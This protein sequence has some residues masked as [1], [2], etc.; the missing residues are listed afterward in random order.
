MG[1][2][3]DGGRGALISESRDLAEKARQA[4]SQVNL[5]DI[6][7]MKLQ[8]EEDQLVGLLNAEETP[9]TE[10][11]NIKVDPRYQQAQLDALSEYDRMSKEGLSLA[12][13]IGL[14]EIN[15]S[16]SNQDKARRNSILAAMQERGALDSGESLAA[17]LLGA[18]ASTQ[19]AQQQGNELNKA[20]INARRDA[21]ANR[22]NLAGQLSEQDYGRQSEMAKSMDAINQ[23]RAQN[24]QNVNQYNLGNKQQIASGNVNLRNTQQ[25][26]NK[27]LNQQQFNNEMAKQGAI[28]SAYGNQSQNALQAASMAQ[29]KKG[30]GGVIGTL[31]GAGIGGAIGAKSGQGAQGAATGANIFGSAGSQMADGGIKGQ[32]FWNGGLKNSPSIADL[33]QSDEMQT[34]T[35]FDPYKKSTAAEQISQSRMNNF[36]T[37]DPYKKRD[38]SPGTF[39]DFFNKLMASKQPQKQPEMDDSK[40]QEQDFLNQQLSGVAN[41]FRNYAEGGI[42]TDEAMDMGLIQPDENAQK[43]LLAIARGDIMPEDSSHGRIIGGNSYSGDKLPDFLNSKEMVLNVDQQD[44]IKHDLDSKTAELEGLRKMFQLL[45]KK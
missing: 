19:S 3:N 32:T 9:D 30:L 31:V 2:K 23:F 5:P 37:F 16:I 40:K 11:K 25:Q 36:G 44:N 26:Y 43:E 29:G 17:Q 12:D 38:S 1:S 22:S 42:R 4:I 21:L 39:A 13:R 41:N 35:T 10:L 34:P 14:D 7:K 15:Q 45:G 6:E 28:A 27:E 18:Q 8:L 33:R 24:R 20:M